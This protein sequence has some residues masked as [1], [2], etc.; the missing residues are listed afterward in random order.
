ME[1]P[2]VELHNIH[3]A[4]GHPGKPV[5]H[6]AG[7]SFGQRRQGVIG[8][9][10]CGKTTL[11]QIAMGLLPPQA[12]EVRFRGHAVKS[13]KDFFALRRAVGF[14][15]Q[16][17]DDQLFCP[18]VL[19]DV[20]FGPLNLGL[21]P[22]Q[23][24]EIAARTLGQLGLEGFEERLTHR[25]SGGEKKLVSL[26]T[27]LAMEPQVLLLDEPTNT[28]D[29]AT[30]GRL[31]ELLQQL[32]LPCVIVSHDWDFLAQTVDEYWTVDHGHVHRCERAAPHTHVHSHPAGAQAHTH[33]S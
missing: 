24:R 15:F 18:T 11:L 5:L 26:A 9:N 8:P 25:L 28:L 30:R 3:Y 21:S 1:T 33:E 2:L 29:P 31:I 10:G 6:G 4:Y 13:E 23:A 7:F 16:H 12:G 19:E 27:V 20:A 32:A 22:A 14:L 17:A